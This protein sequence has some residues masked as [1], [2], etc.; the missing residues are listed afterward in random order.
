ME[1]FIVV[2]HVLLNL[3]FT[4]YLLIILIRSFW[5]MRDKERQIKLKH[6][7]RYVEW[8]FLSLMFLT[9]VYPILVLGTFDL[10]HGIKILLLCGVIWINRFDTRIHFTMTSLVSIAM[11]ALIGFI[12]FK[13]APSLKSQDSFFDSA[14]SISSADLDGLEK[15]RVI[16]NELC[17]TCHGIDGKL[18]KFEAADLSITTLGLGERILVITNGAPLTVMPPF[19]NQLSEDEIEAVASFIEE[20]KKN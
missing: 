20:L 13:K 15:G 2:I 18:R 11:I 5:L 16:F 17:S 10:Y 14:D 6:K 4:L 9:G 19:K 8:I 1:G 3:L 12:S 7:L